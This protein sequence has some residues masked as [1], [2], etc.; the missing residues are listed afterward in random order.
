MATNEVIK[1]LKKYLQ[2]VRS[3]GIPVNKAYL[4]GS[5]ARNQAT[6]ISDIDLLIVSEN[7]FENDDMTIGKIWSLTRKVSTKIEPYLV[8]NERFNN[9]SNS[10]LIQIVKAEG[11][12]IV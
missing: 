1:L 12:V 3:E 7:S 11:I 4:Y 6:D 10:P 2:L 8:G 5:Y 9:D